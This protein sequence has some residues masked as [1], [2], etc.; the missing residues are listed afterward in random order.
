MMTL[1]TY[2]RS[3]G[4]TGAQFAERIEVSEAS[5][6]RIRRGE[7]NISRDLIRRIVEETGGEVSADALVFHADH[8]GAATTNESAGS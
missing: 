5:L 4:I 7:Q 8:A 2:L 3:N 6:T 1:D